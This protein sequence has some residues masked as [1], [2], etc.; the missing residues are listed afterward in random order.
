M[1]N[2]LSTVL[3]AMLQKLP[4]VVVGKKFNSANF[5]VRKKVFAFTKDGGVA[6]K[7][8]PETVKTLVKTR[9]ASLLVMGKRT[10]KEWVVIRYQDPAEAK[11][12]L[13]LFK[14][15]WIM[16]RPKRRAVLLA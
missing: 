1:K 12:H 5:T 4:G 3:A 9:T 8:P 11:K 2:E 14:K 6:L 10:M 15:R 16:F 7:L 13:G